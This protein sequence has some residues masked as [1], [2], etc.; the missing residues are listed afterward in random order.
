MT[1]WIEGLGPAG[2]CDPC[3]KLENTGLH[4]HPQLEW[5]E[6]G[7]LLGDDLRNLLHTVYVNRPAKRLQFYLGQVRGI[8]NPDFR[9]EPAYPRTK[10]GDAGFQLLGLY[11]FWNIIEYWSPYRDVLG[12]NWDAVLKEYIPKVALAK[13]RD[14]YQREMM[15]LIAHAHDTHANLWGSLA[16]RPPVGECQLPLILRFV[17]NQAVVTGYSADAGKS[18]GLKLGDVIAQID[19]VPVSKL[20]TDWTPYYAD[21]NEAAR[22]RDMARSMTRGACGEATLNIRRGTEALAVKATR[23]PGGTIDGRA[24]STH[25]LAG[26]TFRRLSPEIAYLK[27]SSVKA[28][29]TAKYVDLASGTKGLIIDI[30]NY[31]SEFVVFALGQHLV[32]GPTPFVTF[33]EGDL[34]NPGA[35]H[36]GNAIS[37]TPEQPHYAGKVVILVDE[38]SQS[39]AEYTTMAFRSAPGAKVIGST[40]AGA[41]GNVS[42]IPLPGGLHT[43]ISGIGVFYP[44]KKPT[45]RIGI[46]PDIVVRPT[47]AGIREGRDEVLE[48]AVRQIAGRESSPGEVRK[49]IER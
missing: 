44:D 11:R 28:E 49:L 38:V 46:V 35:F 23:V 8:G 6:D 34:S 31:P 37:L 14:D 16:V 27:L 13:T 20:V 4:L 48:E 21:S 19:G 9:H 17:E 2:K 45:Q 12:E 1:K 24:G 10:P 32:D 3:A 40:T 5:L 7:R 36:W 29:D 15:A 43:M 41:D 33:T 26:G 30:R 22:Q 42:N 18:M 47:I 39:Q 25:D